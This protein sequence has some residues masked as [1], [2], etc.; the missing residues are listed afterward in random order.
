MKR[1]HP[2]K[3]V[4]LSILKDNAREDEDNDE[5]QIHYYL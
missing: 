5:Q 2:L 1:T 4:D 3:T